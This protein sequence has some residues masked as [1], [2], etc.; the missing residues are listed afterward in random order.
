M[1]DKVEL[2]KSKA[3]KFRSLLTEHQL[4]N[5]DAMLLLRWLEPLFDEIEQGKVVPPKRYDYRNALGKD[6]PFYEPNSPFSAAEADFSAALEDW[7]SQSWYQQST[8]GST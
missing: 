2:L 4:A 1:V 8:N 3:E 7:A 5:G 6:S